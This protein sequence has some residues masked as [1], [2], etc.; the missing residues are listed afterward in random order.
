MRREGARMA[1]THCAILTVIIIAVTVT[2]ARWKAF[3][4]PVVIFLGF[5][6]LIMLRVAGRK[7][8]STG[9]D[10]VYGMMDTGIMSIFAL[11][12]ASIAGILGGIIGAGIGDAI[13]DAF[14]GIFEGKT[15]ELLRK[16]G[17][18][19]ER[20]PLSISMGKMSGCLI[21]FGVVVTFT[22][23]IMGL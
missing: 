20:T 22:W 2:V 16:L 9:A 15:S 12:G 7:I 5:L 21:G 6:P 1:L 17:I 13:T 8:R 14:A 18:K 23:T 10:I 3:V 11:A 19:E 4:G